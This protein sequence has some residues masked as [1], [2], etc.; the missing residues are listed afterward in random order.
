MFQPSLFEVHKRTRDVWEMSDDA[1]SEAAAVTTELLRRADYGPALRFASIVKLKMG[2][3]GN[4]IP[5]T[6]A[7]AFADQLDAVT[8]RRLDIKEAV[9]EQGEFLLALVDR[10][11]RPAERSGGHVDG[12]VVRS[13]EAGING[14]RAQFQMGIGKVK[15][16]FHRLPAEERASIVSAQSI[17]KLLTDGAVTTAGE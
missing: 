9:E 11:G 7:R 4:S 2:I 5:D 17:T 16:N 3:E 1:I 14:A 8:E 6:M 12:F 15:A 10:H 13:S